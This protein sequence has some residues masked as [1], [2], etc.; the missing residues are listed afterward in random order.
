MK[1]P[2][3]ADSHEFQEHQ[4]HASPVTKLRVSFDDQY[5]FSAAEDGCLF[6]YKIMDK[7]GRVN[8]REKDVIYADEVG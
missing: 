5:L 7:E 1:F 8:K 4:A 3:S 2:L 6:I